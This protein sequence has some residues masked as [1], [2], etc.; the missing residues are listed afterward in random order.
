MSAEQE[1]EKPQLKT[2]KGGCHCR[3]FEFEYSY[4]SFEEK[5]PAVCNCSY[6]IIQDGILTFV[7]PVDLISI[8]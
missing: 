1:T 7:I 8:Y 6:C 3:R 5:P 2:Y 4:P